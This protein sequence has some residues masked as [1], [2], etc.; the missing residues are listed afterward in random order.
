MVLLQKLKKVVYYRV[1]ICANMCFYACVCVQFC[2]DSIKT[3]ASNESNFN[4]YRWECDIALCWIL[5]L[6]IYTSTLCLNKCI[7]WFVIWFWNLNKKIDEIWIW[8]KPHLL[9]FRPDHW[10]YIDY[11]NIKKQT[12]DIMK[13]SVLTNSFNLL[14]TAFLYQISAAKTCLWYNAFEKPQP[15]WRWQTEVCHETTASRKGWY[16]ENIIC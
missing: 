12:L 1:C 2:F 15:D 4:W 7:G 8:L 11:F 9:S 6:V 5:V 14:T 10:D 13:I 16:E 3:L